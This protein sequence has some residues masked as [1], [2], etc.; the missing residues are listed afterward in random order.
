MDRW[1]DGWVIGEIVLWVD[2]WMGKEMV[3]GICGC[4]DGWWDEYMEVLV[5]R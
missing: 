4:M 1:T 3:K 5:N 2:E